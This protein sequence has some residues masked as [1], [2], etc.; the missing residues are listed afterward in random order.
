MSADTTPLQVVCA[1]IERH[2]LVLMARR[3]AHKHLGGKWE[4][5]GGKVEPGEATIDALH[6]ELR[7]EL[8]CTVEIIRP[9]TSHTHAY[10]SVT[11]CLRPFVVRLT[12]NS[13]EPQAIEH[14]ALAWIPA[15]ELTMLDLPAADL[16]IIA[17]YLSATKRS[18]PLD[19][20]STASDDLL[21]NNS[22]K[23]RVDNPPPSL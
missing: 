13:R 17:D 5:P 11:V 14:S 21:E 20:F 9:L 16:P 18:E 6:R 8:G 3:P 7:E 1:L 23:N 19:A 15:N 10:A 22:V 12:A 4:F 2:G